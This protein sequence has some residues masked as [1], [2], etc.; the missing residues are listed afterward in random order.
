M[1]WGPRTISSP[2][3]PGGSVSPLLTSMMRALVAGSGRPMLPTRRSPLRGLECVED[4]AAGKG[5]GEIHTTGDAVAMGKGED[6]QYDG[7]ASLCVCHPVAL[8][9]D[10]HDEVAMREH[11][12]FG[13]VG[14][15]GGI[16]Q[17]CQ[18]F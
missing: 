13:R 11:D 7:T 9:C 16:L 3:S 1:T 2:T 18:V 6:A 10:V 8:L 17:Q 5:D 4:E 12:A 15:A 14:C